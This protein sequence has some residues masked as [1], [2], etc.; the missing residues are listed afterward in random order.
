MTHLASGF[1]VALPVGWQVAVRRQPPSVPGRSGN[2]LV[3]AATV[4]IP[5]E[6]GD[7]GSGIVS[8]L[9]SEDL[10]V[11]FFEYDYEAAQTPLFVAQG[12]PKPRPADF[13]PSAMQRVLPGMSGGQWFFTTSGRAWCLQI[14][15]GSHARRT[16]GAV[17]VGAFLAG[18]R[19]GRAA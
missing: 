6:R 10:F 4:T 14:V 18:V 3:H 1:E 19:I 13:S 8:T 2:L 5:R 12:L 7:F 17:K 16:A 11:T 9:G 15:L